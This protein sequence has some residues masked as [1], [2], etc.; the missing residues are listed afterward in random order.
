MTGFWRQIFLGRDLWV[1]LAA[2]ALPGALLDYQ[3]LVKA[4]PTL[5]S[6]Q[7]QVAPALLGVALAGLAVLVVF[8]DRRYIALLESV[9]PGIAADIFP[10]QWTAALAVVTLVLSLVLGYVSVMPES[11]W[12]LFRASFIVALWSFLYLLWS[13]LD[14]LAFL[15]AHARNRI[16]QLKA[17]QQSEHRDDEASPTS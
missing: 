4:S 12:V 10:F 5:V 13:V 9:P 8:L 2:S 7:L 15:A 14:L 11:Y 1:T 16:T 3:T 17:E 6:A